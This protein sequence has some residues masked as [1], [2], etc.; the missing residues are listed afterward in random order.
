MRISHTISFVLALAACKSEST[1]PRTAAAPPLAP[2]TVGV[3][4]S[5][6]LAPLANLGARLHEEAARRPHVEVPAERLFHALADRGISLASEKQ[7][8]AATAAAAYCALG[9]TPETVAIAVCEYPSREAAAAG[10]RLLD[11]RYAKL[12]PDAV[13]AIHGSTLVTIAHGARHP[14]IRDQVLATF[15][16]L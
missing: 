2:A 14:E 4:G 11:T 16:S 15:Q 6:D 12:V 1:P 7:V 9:V 10:K 3:P 5:Q 8:L 13:R